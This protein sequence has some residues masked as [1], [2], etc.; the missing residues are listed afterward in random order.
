[1]FVCVCVRNGYKREINRKAKRILRCQK[2]C[3]RKRVA[4][5]QQL[6]TTTIIAESFFP[7]ECLVLSVVGLVNVV[8]NRIERGKAGRF[9]FIFFDFFPFL[10][11]EKE[12]I[13]L[14]L[15]LAVI[16]CH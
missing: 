16:G 1:M 15:Q 3:Q 10:K 5:L 4:N 7:L 11:S 14:F 6:E 2:Q 12:M 8:A 13:G 9:F